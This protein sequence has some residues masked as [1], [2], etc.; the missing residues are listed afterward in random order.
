MGIEEAEIRAHREV[1]DQ[2]AQF[3]MRVAWGNDIS[4]G[5]IYFTTRAVAVIDWDLD[6]ADALTLTLHLWS[7]Q[8]HHRSHRAA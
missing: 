7:R 1:E 4:E 8:G 2:L 6:P 5:V 3:G